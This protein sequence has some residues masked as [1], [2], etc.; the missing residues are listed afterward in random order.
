MAA[1]S[2]MA[3]EPVVAEATELASPG[4]TMASGAAKVNCT[5]GRISQCSGSKGVNEMGGNSG[6][7]GKGGK[8]R[9]KQKQ[10][11][12]QRHQLY[13]WHQWHHCNSGGRWRGT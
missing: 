12:Y 10:Q 3:A 8:M 11:R 1:V 4:A 9:R 6:G 5:G 7:K 2:V 13:Q